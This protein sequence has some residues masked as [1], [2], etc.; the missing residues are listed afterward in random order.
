M[1]HCKFVLRGEWILYFV[2]NNSDNI[3]YT[4]LFR[5]V[6]FLQFVNFFCIFYFFLYASYPQI[7]IPIIRIKVEIKNGINTLFALR[8]I[9]KPLRSFTVHGFIT[10]YTKQ[11]NE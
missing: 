8:D 5:Q 11:V 6:Y 9:M 2:F 7:S 3:T 1:R 10:A 4:H